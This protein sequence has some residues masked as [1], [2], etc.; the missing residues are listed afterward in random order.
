MVVSQW[1][2]TQPVTIRCNSVWCR[3]KKK[4]KRQ[5]QMITVADA[6]ILLYPKESWCR[7]GF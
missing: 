4:C 5:L 2:R 7:H 1:S 6:D 3:Q